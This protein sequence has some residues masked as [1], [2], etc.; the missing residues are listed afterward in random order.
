MEQA[1]GHSDQS[2]MVPC[3]MVSRVNSLR[4]YRAEVHPGYVNVTYGY[5]ENPKPEDVTHMGFILREPPAKQGHMFAMPCQPYCGLN[6][7]RFHDTCFTCP[8]PRIRAGKMPSIFPVRV[9]W[10]TVHHCHCSS[11]TP[12]QTGVGRVKSILL[13]SVL[14]VISM[15]GF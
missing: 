13:K 1:E 9:K 3:E 4:V 6:L 5:E 11:S 15:L 14:S 2:T 10:L 8:I 7:N 12:H